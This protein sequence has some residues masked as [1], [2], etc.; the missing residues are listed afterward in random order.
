M[1]APDT[2]LSRGLFTTPLVAALRRTDS[3]TT[4]TAKS[5]QTYSIS[6]AKSRI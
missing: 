3:Y 5:Q 6:S 2:I 4:V 1:N